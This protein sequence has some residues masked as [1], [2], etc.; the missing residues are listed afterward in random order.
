MSE[1]IAIAWISLT[2]SVHSFLGKNS[3]IILNNIFGEFSY[4]CFEVV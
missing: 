2:V 3:K 1:N 4:N